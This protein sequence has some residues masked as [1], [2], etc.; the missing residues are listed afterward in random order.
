MKKNK[1]LNI[2]GALLDRKQL[3][4]YLEKIASEHNLQKKSNKNTYPIYRLKENFDCVESCN[5]QL[6][7]SPEKKLKMITDLFEVYVGGES[8]E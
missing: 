6:K 4:V 8:D 5:V 1:Y 7:E 2:K 3:E